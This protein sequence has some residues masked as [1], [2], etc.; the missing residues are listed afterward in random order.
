M[1]TWINTPIQEGVMSAESHKKTNKN[2][3]L[4]DTDTA[5]TPSLAQALSSLGESM[6]TTRMQYLTGAPTHINPINNTALMQIRIN[7][8]NPRTESKH[9]NDLPDLPP[10]APPPYFDGIERP[11]STPLSTKPRSRQV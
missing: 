4:V 8:D 2:N 1:D 7:Q 9:Y 5:S 11:A 3:L 6:G 10:P